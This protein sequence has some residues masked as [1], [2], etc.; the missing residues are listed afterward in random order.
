MASD[1]V[2]IE[3]FQRY[4]RCKSV[5]PD[6]SQGYEDAGLLLQ[7]YAKDLGLTFERLD[8]EKGHPTFILTLPGTDPSL[9]CI[10][11]NSHMDVVPVEQEKWTKDAWSA[12]IEDGKI[13]GRGTQDMKSVGIQY[14]EAIRTL[15]ST[16]FQPKRTISLAYVPDEEVGGGRGM[17]LLLLH[18]RM[19]QL[20]PAFVLDEGLASPGDKFSVFKGERKIWWVKL[21][22]EGAVGHGSR[23]IANTAVPK[24]LHVL[25]RLSAMRDE[26]AAQLEAT[27]ACGKQ[28]GDFTSVNIT[29][30]RAGNTTP[31]VFQY[32]VIP[33]VA[34]AG[35]DIRIPCTVDLPAFKAQLDAWCTEASG[36][37]AGA[38][39]VTWEIVSGLADGALENPVTEVS[40]THGWWNAFQQ[41]VAASGIGLHE[42]S[43][44]PAAT[45]C[46]WIRLMLSVPALG[47]SP[48]RNCPI[49]LHEH[50]EYIPI[51]VFLE[52]IKV[53]EKL[54]PTLA[55]AEVPDVPMP[56]HK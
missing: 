31:G 13:Y 34:E 27:C 14:L 28:L 55:N 30:L 42:P 29:M 38:G 47:F 24:L 52:G 23:F 51:S 44:F 1:S 56:W 39:S 16:G 3:R 9:G 54:I 36:T 21:R 6:P 33:S 7:E 4:L 40:E 10:L 25:N 19:A 15:R 37:G 11:L 2:A 48:M 5:H 20:K 22:A 12:H 35:I 17:K 45:D 32:N 18:E 8:L 50:D 41:G 49:L 53:Y 43:V 26:Q 46:R